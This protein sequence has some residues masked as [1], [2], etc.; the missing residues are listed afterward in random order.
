MIVLHLLSII[1]MFAEIYALKDIEYIVYT[2]F[3]NISRFAF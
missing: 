2:V 3:K 1:P